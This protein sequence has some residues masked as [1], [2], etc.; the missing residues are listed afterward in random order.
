MFV[1]VGPY[2]SSTVE[3]ANE[4]HDY[5]AIDSIAFKGG[6]ITMAE[7]TKYRRENFSDG[8]KLALR[9]KTAGNDDSESDRSDE[10]DTQPH[11]KRKV[12]AKATAD[13]RYDSIFFFF[14]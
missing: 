10:Y 6:P 5:G 13:V 2:S 7:H 14:L 9:K 8:H 3:L 11:S 1:Y 4:D 12:M